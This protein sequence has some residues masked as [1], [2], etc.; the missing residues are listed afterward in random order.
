MTRLALL[1]LSLLFTPF[2]AAQ[3][4]DGTWHADTQRLM[5]SEGDTTR[6]PTRQSLDLSTDGGIVTGTARFTTS[7]PAN[8]WNDGAD[9]Y[10]IDAGY[11]LMGIGD[12]EVVMSSANGTGR[13][14]TFLTEVSDDGRLT[15]TRTDGR[16][17][18]VVYQRESSAHAASGTWSAVTARPVSSEGETIVARASQTLVLDVADGVLDGLSH[19]VVAIPIGA[20]G[21]R[22]ECA[23]QVSARPLAGSV[24][25]DDVVVF[26]TTPQREEGRALSFR[27]TLADGGQRLVVEP[28]FESAIG[29]VEYRRVALL[30][31]R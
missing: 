5:A 18:P 6:V 10:Q 31:A 7:F 17:A 28:L 16:L 23:E 9:A 15:M 26:Q 30:S 13:E 27:A 19:Y 20:W 11:V 25:S 12:G 3:G 4:L 8:V 29:P 21:V 22:A 2:A 1:T 24:E 14:V